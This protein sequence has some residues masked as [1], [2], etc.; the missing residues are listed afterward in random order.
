MSGFSGAV[1]PYDAV[2]IAVGAQRREWLPG[3]LHF[4]GAES[5]AAFAGLLAGFEDG[6]DQR[7]CFVNPA[8]LSWTLPLYE[9]ALLTAST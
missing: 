7:L 1:L 2:V 4:G 9:L 6:S 5:V 3:A 8:G